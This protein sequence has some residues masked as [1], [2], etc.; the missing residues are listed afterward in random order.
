MDPHPSVGQQSEILNAFRDS[1]RMLD[2]TTLVKTVREDFMNSEGIQLYRNLKPVI[3]RLRKVINEA[4][5]FRKDDNPVQFEKST[6][7]YRLSIVIGFARKDE[8][9]VMFEAVGNS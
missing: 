2:R 5:D 4:L 7:A 8:G 3:S 6:K 1:N 9:G